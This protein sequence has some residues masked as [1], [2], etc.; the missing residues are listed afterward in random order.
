MGEPQRVD[1]AA[2]PAP[3][4][5]KIRPMLT[6]RAA[7]AKVKD[8]RFGA[9][10]GEAAEVAGLRQCSIPGLNSV[11]NY[12]RYRQ[13]V[14][15]VY[16]VDLED[17]NYFAVGTPNWESRLP[18][19]RAWIV[20]AGEF[21]EVTIA[22][23]P[24]GHEKYGVFRDSLGMSGLRDVLAE[25]E[26]S[27]IKV[28]VR[29]ASEAN[30]RLSE[31]SAYGSRE[32]ADRFFQAAAWFKEYMPPNVEMVFSPLIN[33][34]VL[35]DPRQQDAIRWMFLGSGGKIPWDRIGGTIYRTDAKLEPAYDK[36]YQKMAAMNADLPF[37]ICELGGPFRLRDEM[38][39][40]IAQVVDGRWNRISKINLFARD[41]NKRA[42]PEGHFGFMDPQERS[43]ATQMARN[44]GQPKA[45]ESFLRQFLTQ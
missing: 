39:D 31:Y 24:L 3:V 42:D 35:G 15:D 33:T 7:E 5:R 25:A 44:G 19:L 17:M 20:R 16:G 18:A 4:S 2:E 23:E 28:V 29:F 45:V 10:A 30:L 37:Q 36:Y 27:G 22:I 11:E 13:S 1:S 43:I 8:I 40:F 21:G 26:S 14:R 9:F 38:M 34:V 6:G 12:R 32:A 41:I